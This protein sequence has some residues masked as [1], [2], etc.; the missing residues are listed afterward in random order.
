MLA[1]EKL[2]AMFSEVIP[3]SFSFPEELFAPYIQN[4]RLARRDF[5][6][7]ASNSN[8]ADM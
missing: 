6:I 8:A 7:F 4:S 1:V 5:V 2:V 3:P